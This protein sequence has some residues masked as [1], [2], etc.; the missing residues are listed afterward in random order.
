M[1]YRDNGEALLAQNEAIQA[2]LKLERNQWT[3]ERKEYQRAV[4]R[5]L[6][7][8]RELRRE[9]VSRLP[10]WAVL[11]LLGLTVLAA[12]MGAVNYDVMARLHARG[13]L[14]SDPVAVK[15]VSEEHMQQ[16]L[17]WSIA[18][19][20]ALFSVAAVFA[21][22]LKRPRVAVRLGGVATL[23]ALAIFF[24]S[25]AGVVAKSLLVVFFL[26]LLGIALRALV[27]RARR[28]PE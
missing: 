15:Q 25:S 22:L 8:M 28:I 17:S 26:T 14:L 7:R 6:E 11:L 5:L 19:G 1:S 24:T 16:L 2:E 3:S 9:S 20:T 12:Y 21:F 18:A 13:D 4:D 27:Q 10:L 23:A